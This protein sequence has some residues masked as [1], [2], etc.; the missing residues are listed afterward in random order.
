MCVGGGGVKSPPRILRPKSILAIACSELV[1]VVSSRCYAGLQRVHSAHVVFPWRAGHGD[2]NG[3]QGGGWIKNNKDLL[4]KTILVQF[5]I[6]PGEGSY[7]KT[8]RENQQGLRLV[9]SC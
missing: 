8:A 2:G 5:L 4:F 6:C 9:G 7:Q 1:S 3:R